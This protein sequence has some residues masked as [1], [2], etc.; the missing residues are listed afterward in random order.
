MCRLISP[1]VS[2][3]L[4]FFPLGDFYLHW[5]SGAEALFP[6][7]TGGVSSIG[8]KYANHKFSFEECQARH[9]DLV[10]RLAEIFHL[11]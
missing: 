4:P 1:Y 6:T 5:Q 3:D 11:F 7:F 9:A 8:G 10:E 2:A